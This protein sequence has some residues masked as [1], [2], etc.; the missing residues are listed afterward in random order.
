MTAYK[1]TKYPIMNLQE[2]LLSILAC[3]FVDD[4]VIGAPYMVSP[5]LL[6]HFNI[7]VVVHGKKTAPGL[8]PFTGKVHKSCLTFS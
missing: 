8:D 7:S 4:V 5:E 1:G 2:R 6:D 3:K